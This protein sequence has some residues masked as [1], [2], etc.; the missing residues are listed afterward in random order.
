[1]LS[2]WYLVC[3]TMNFDNLRDLDFNLNI[4]PVGSNLAKSITLNDNN[5]NGKTNKKKSMN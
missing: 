5:A 3:T 4:Q 1:M 2:A